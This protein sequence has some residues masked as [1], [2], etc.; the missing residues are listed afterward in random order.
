MRKKIAM[1]LALI[2]LL[3]TIVACANDNEEPA[4]PAAA[5]EEAPPVETEEEAPPAATEDDPAPPEE[6][7]EEETEEEGWSGHINVTLPSL[8]ATME[9]WEEIAAA[10]MAINP[11]VTIEINDI[12]IDTYTDWLTAQ[13]AGGEILAD[14]VVSNTVAHFYPDGI[15]VDFSLYLNRPNPYQDNVPWREVM[16]HHAYTF[17]RRLSPDGQIYTLNIDTHQLPWFYNRDMFARLN[18]EPPSDWEELI[19]ISEIILEAGYVPLSIGGDADSF[20]SGVYGWLVMRYTDQYWKDLMYRVAAQPG[21]YLFDPEIDGVWEFDITDRFIDD[22]DRVNFNPLRFLRMIV[23]GEAGPDSD[24]Y[25]EMNANF[26]RVFPEFAGGPA[27][28]GTSWSEAQ[29]RFIRG[30]AAMT[31]DGSWFAAGFARTMEDAPEPFE[32]GYF[33]DPPM[34]GDHIATEH[35]RRSTGFS[36]F[37]SVVNKTREQNDLVMD[38]MMF[39]IS[40]QGQTMRMQGLDRI[41]HAPSGSVQVYGVDLPEQWQD[42]LGPLA[43]QMDGNAYNNPLTGFARGLFSE[44]ESVREFQDLTQRFLNGNIT[45]EEYSLEMH[46][47]ILDAIPRYLEHMGFRED[48]LDDPSRDPR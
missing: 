5:E 29:D 28:F 18:I 16:S 38:F 14:I 31:V 33:W 17:D 1:L 41:N 19:E 35:V 13:I 44:P 24:R 25:R 15:F 10:Y 48:A 30:E 37:L 2:L 32:L 4:P 46:Q 36:G 47:V 23:D 26:A 20:Y 9:V 6:V 22:L 8:G 12:D 40:Q 11:G 39:Y 42:V 7:S 45:V 21:D 3:S 27:F 43:L 34:R